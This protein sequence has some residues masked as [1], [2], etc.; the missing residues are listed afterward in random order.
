MLPENQD[1]GRA[2]HPDEEGSLLAE[3]VNP[4]SVCYTPTVLALNTTVRH[5]EISRLR[6]SQVNLLTR[7]LTVGRSKTKAGNGRVI[8]MNPDTHRVLLEWR[9]K[10]PDAKPDHYVFPFCEH[11]W[12]G[13]TRP[14]K[15]WRA[16][17]ENA[18]KRSGVQ[19]RFHG[20]RH[21]AI[22]KMSEGQASDQTIMAIAGHVS[23]KMLEHYSHIRMEAKRRALDGI[24]GSA[25]FRDR[26]Q[27]R[28]Q[29]ENIQNGSAANFLN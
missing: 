25:S 18:R 19:C 26:T 24:S 27:N 9:A 16:A 12:I 28:T 6:W 17:C 20:L 2:F 7:V 4:D 10:S 29:V 22:S 1:V 3:C 13:P 21:T 11:K 5:D 15:G 14:I 23:R 8:P